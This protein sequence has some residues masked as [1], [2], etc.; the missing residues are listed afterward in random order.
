M[1]EASAPPQT[2]LQARAREAFIAACRLDVDVA[3]PGNVSWRSAGHGMVAA[4]FIES[5][6]AAAGPLFQ[7]GA[8]VGRR[9]LEAVS[10]TRARVGCNTNLGIVLLVA[11]LA[12]A[13]DA[14]DTCDAFDTFDTSDSF[15]ASAGYDASGVSDGAEAKAACDASAAL[16]DW[17]ASDTPPGGAPFPAAPDARAWQSE[18][19]RVLARLDVDDARAAYQAIAL[20]APGGLGDAPEQSVRA[21]PTVDLRTAMTLAAQRDSIA[22]QYAEGF[23]DIF[24]HGLTALGAVA[25]RRRDI[26]TLDVFFAFLARWPDSHIVRKHG[27]PV[28][29]SVTLAARE[30]HARWRDLLTNG[31]AAEAAATVAAWDAE[32]KGRGLNPGTSADLTVA[33]LFVALVSGRCPPPAVRATPDWHETC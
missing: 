20:A 7:R 6:R 30:R 33:T 18:T 11:P 24:G 16:N 9:I 13:L 21:P 8:P 27:L 4:Q 5:A 17:D 15:A 22:R 19:R 31:A 14:F 10:A 28:A 2:D 1:R 23:V 32:L 12:A 3:K 29:Q 25:A 26:A